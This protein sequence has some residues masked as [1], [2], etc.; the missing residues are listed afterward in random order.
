MCVFSRSRR[1]GRDPLF[2]R[3]PWAFPNEGRRVF[4]LGSSSLASIARP[5]SAA[6]VNLTRGKGVYKDTLKDTSKLSRYAA[7]ARWT[8]GATPEVMGTAVMGSL[9]LARE[10][11]SGKQTRHMGLSLLE[12]KQEK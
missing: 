1:G 6:M 7:L 10:A 11:A 3:F 5:A 4:T 8:M 12:K 9:R 2:R